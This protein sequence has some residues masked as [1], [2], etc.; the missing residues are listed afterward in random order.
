MK[1]QV[2]I[3]RTALAAAVAIGFSLPLSAQQGTTTD[4][5]TLDSESAEQ[6]SKKR[7]Y[8]PYVGRNFPTRPLFGDTQR[9]APLF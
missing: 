9:M 3:A 7:P 5:G 6:A 2:N 4:I 8:S 1:P